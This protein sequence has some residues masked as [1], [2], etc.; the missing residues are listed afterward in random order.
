MIDVAALQSAFASY[1]GAPAGSEGVSVRE[2]P[3]RPIQQTPLWIAARAGKLEVVKLLV[4]HG[5]KVDAMGASTVQQRP[6]EIALDHRRLEVMRYLIE[7]GAALDVAPPEFGHPLLMTAIFRNDFA[8]VRLL[9]EKGA[10]V[11]VVSRYGDTPL[12]VAIEEFSCISNYDAARDRP[13]NDREIENMR[14]LLEHGADPRVRG[15]D[16]LDALGKVEKRFESRDLH[17]DYQERHR[18]IV[19]LIKKHT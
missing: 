17:P 9:V 1:M 18:E 2:P 19:E 16:G 12:H 7:R 8:A 3:A 4:E 15:K 11:N 5:A 10:N 14:F 13:E 6:I